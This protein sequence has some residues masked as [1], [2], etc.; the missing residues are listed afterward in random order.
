MQALSADMSETVF[1]KAVQR[2]A[3]NRMPDR[4]H[5]HAD[6]MRPSGFELKG[7]MGITAETMQHLITGCDGVPSAF[8][9]SHFFAIGF[10]ACNRLIDGPAVQFRDPMTIASY[11][12]TGGMPQSVPRGFDVR[13]RF[14][15][16]PATRWY[17]Y[18]SGVQCRTQFAIDTRQAG[19]AMEHQCVYQSAGPVSAAG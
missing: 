11:P 19:P 7:H 5:M 13:C 17:P 18:R 10:M 15:P 9:H 8:H 4:R 14:W 12:R 6:L 3:D 16:Q 1:G 2:I